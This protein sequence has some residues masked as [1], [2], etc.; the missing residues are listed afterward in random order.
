MTLPGGVLLFLEPD[1]TQMQIESFFASNDIPKNRVEAIKGLANA[2][3]VETVPGFPSLALANEPA[4]QE[5]VAASSPN[6][7][8]EL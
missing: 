5:G 2:F 7:G 3:L 6:W 1:L 8:L 4:G